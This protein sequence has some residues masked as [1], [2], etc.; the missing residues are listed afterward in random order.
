LDV[1]WGRFG[2][3]FSS[4]GAVFD[5]HWGR[6]GDGPFW[7][8][9]FFIGLPL[10]V[11]KNGVFGGFEGEDVKILCDNPQKSQPGVN[12]RLLVYWMSKSV[13]RPML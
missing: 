1:S 2:L 6:F 10:Y 12:M 4:I 9:P 5:L 7:S 13:Q 3:V 8:V 11:P